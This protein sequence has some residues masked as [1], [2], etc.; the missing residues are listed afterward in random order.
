MTDPPRERRDSLVLRPPSRTEFNV[1]DSKLMTLAAFNHSPDRTLAQPSVTNCP[2]CGSTVSSVSP[3]LTYFHL[4]ENVFKSQHH[5]SVPEGCVSGFYTAFFEEI[6]TIGSGAFGTVKEVV[7]RLGPHQLASYAAKIIPVGEF[8]YNS[9]W[10]LKAIREVQLLSKLNHPNIISYK[11]A[12]VEP[13]QLS[14]FAPTVP[15]LFILMELGLCSVSY[16]L[17]TSIPIA[18]TV[19]ADIAM[20]LA[21]LEAHGIIHGDVKPANILLIYDSDVRSCRF[22]L[23]DLGQ[24]RDSQETSVDL[25]YGTEAYLPEKS[26][27]RAKFCRDDIYS[28]GISFLETVVGYIPE[29]TDIVSTIRSLPTFLHGSLL[30]MLME[31]ESGRCG[32]RD[33]IENK[34]V[35]EM[36]QRGREE[37]F[38]VIERREKKDIGGLLPP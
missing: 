10:L 32:G 17:P 35:V 1:E 25:D 4:V 5:Q 29:R 13:Y 33:V 6:R 23:S 27:G 24:S 12:W 16:L 38:R 30:S 21:H 14:P 28:L 11:Y 3:A 31:E 15:H 34:G 9:K 18:C 7:H 2:L 37:L 20:G 26:R 36:A 22:V 8:S 19:L